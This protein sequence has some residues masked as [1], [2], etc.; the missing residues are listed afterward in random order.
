MNP[1]L[2]KLMANL[3]RV[4]K[5]LTLMSGKQHI[6]CLYNHGWK[7][8]HHVNF[9]HKEYSCTGFRNANEAVKQT[10]V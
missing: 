7:E 4:V 10:H 1:W 8:E 5:I 2:K 9:G 6:V 3:Q